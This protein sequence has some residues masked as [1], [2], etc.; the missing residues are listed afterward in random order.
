MRSAAAEL[1]I[2]RTLRDS[3]DLAGAEKHFSRS[4]ALHARAETL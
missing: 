4:L 3:G 2:A 1:E